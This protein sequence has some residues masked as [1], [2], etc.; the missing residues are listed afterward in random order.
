MWLK[1][2]NLPNTQIHSE[3]QGNVIELAECC[4]QA[5]EQHFNFSPADGG[6]SS[7]S[8]RGLGGAE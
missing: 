7:S 4:V 2:G 6:F 1:I 8:H 5:L 3:E